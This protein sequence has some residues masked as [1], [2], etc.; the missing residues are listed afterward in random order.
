MPNPSVRAAAEGLPKVI[1]NT[2]AEFPPEYGMLM[3]GDDFAPRVNDGDTL[4][5]SATETPSRDDLV[6]AW[7]RPDKMKPS[8]EQAG[9]FTLYMGHS[10]I[11]L[12][13]DDHPESTAKPCFILQQA[14]GRRAVIEANKLLAVHKCTDIVKREG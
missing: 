14:D 7:K 12:P 1:F 8:E 6:I 11:K 2:I 3:R 9:I 4:V 10:D 13:F 5:F